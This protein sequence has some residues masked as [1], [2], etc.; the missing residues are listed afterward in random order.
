MVVNDDEPYMGNKLMLQPLQQ[1]HLMMHM[2]PLQYLHNRML[3]DHN[4]DDDVDRGNEMDYTHDVQLIH[5]VV[6]DDDDHA[7]MK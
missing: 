6:D 5:E 3:L 7:K 1:Q 2:N 4:N